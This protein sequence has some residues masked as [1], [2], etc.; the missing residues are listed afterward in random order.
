MFLYVEIII[1]TKT[2][3]LTNHSIGQY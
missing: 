3:V 1:K 2:S